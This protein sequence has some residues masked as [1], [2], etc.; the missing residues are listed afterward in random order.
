MSRF[1]KYSIEDGIS[2]EWE[3]ANIMMSILVY[4]YREFNCRKKQ[5]SRSYR[6]NL[7]SAWKKINALCLPFITNVYFFLPWRLSYAFHGVQ[8]ASTETQFNI[9]IY[10]YIYVYTIRKGGGEERGGE[11]HNHYRGCDSFVSRNAFFPTVRVLFST[12]KEYQFC[13]SQWVRDN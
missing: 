5:F 7:N 4:R 12:V 13:T 10:V 9:Y 8:N 1:I 3:S 11:G 2:M 6:N